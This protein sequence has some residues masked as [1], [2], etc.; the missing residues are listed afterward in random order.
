MINL[1]IG[2]LPA[3]DARYI[4]DLY[5]KIMP[6]VDMKHEF[7]CP[8]CGYEQEAEVPFTTDFFWPK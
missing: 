1:F 8:A 4:R 6:N 5:S 7:E 2:A 3:S